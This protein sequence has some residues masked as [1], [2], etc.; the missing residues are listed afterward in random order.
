MATESFASSAPTTV[1]H[2]L[3]R[4]TRWAILLAGSLLLALWL[5]DP[6]RRAIPAL[7]SSFADVAANLVVKVGNGAFPLLVAAVL[8]LLARRLGRPE[9]HRLARSVLISAL[10][11]GLAVL[12]LKPLVARHELAY[13]QGP[14]ADANWLEQRWG[15]FPSGH[16]AVAFAIATPLARGFPQA[17]L[18]LYAIAALV[19][20]ARLYREAH[21]LSDVLFGGLIGLAIARWSQRFDPAAA[22]PDATPS[23]PAASRARRAKRLPSW[24]LLLLLA[25]PQLFFCL[26]SW[27]LSDPDEGRYAT[28]AA[29]MLRR[30]DFIT[31]TLNQTLYFEKPPLFYWLI[32]AT[33][34]MFEWEAWAARLVPACS[35]M[36]GIFVTYLWGRRSFG[37]RAGRWSAIMLATTLIWPILGRFLIIDMTLAVL[38]LST[39]AAWWSIRSR[40][41]GSHAIDVALFWIGLGLSCLAKGPVAV[42]LI[43]GSIVGYALVAGEGRKLLDRRWWRGAPLALLVAAPW[44]WLVGVRH[45]EF[46]QFFWYEQHVG[47]FLGLDG[48]VEHEQPIWFYAVTVPLGLFPWSAL[49]P[50]LLLG[51]LRRFWPLTTERRRAVTYLAISTLV[52]VG[53]FSI[54]RCKLITYTLP[55]VP[56]LCLLLGAKLDEA[57]RVSRLRRHQVL[58]RGGG[59]IVVALLSAALLLSLFGPS[60][61]RRIENVG[62]AP[63][64]ALAAVVAGWALAVATIVWR[65][66]HAL[67]VPT[68][69]AGAVGLTVGLVLTMVR[70]APNHTIE[71]LLAQLRPGLSGG[72]EVVTYSGWMPSLPFYLERRIR[73]FGTVGELQFGLRALP[74]AERREWYATDFASLQRYM[75]QERPI[76]CIV[77]DH[78]AAQELVRRL[79]DGYAE[80]AWNYRR[81]VIGNRQ[82]VAALAGADT[83]SR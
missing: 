7:H 81:S 65:G 48:A 30:G 8:F 32:A 22:P 5:D 15:R 29:E 54:S 44:F 60:A 12:V 58:W 31:P 69:A 17:A 73:I 52:I 80:V 51:R 27:P 39:L 42:L 10:L 40:R 21:L 72:G 3:R 79:G 37:E 18:V 64:L 33:F 1:W 68:V 6:V 76:Y 19:G 16:T 77:G 24:L 55:A 70:L 82:A 49:L 71:P 34:R 67:F 38:M 35:A 43:L 41:D 62:P 75:A 2:G 53:F 4:G 28:I 36:I 45:P 11:T 66:R 20:V 9:L 56:L 63:A 78:K 26:G 57:F 59:V 83:A 25:I 47:R 14:A 13:E 23:A 74:T 50:L 61:L 46:N